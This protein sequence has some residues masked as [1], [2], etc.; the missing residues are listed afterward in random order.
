MPSDVWET[1]T[2]KLYFSP[3]VRYLIGVLPFCLRNPGADVCHTKADRLVTFLFL[4]SGAQLDI[5]LQFSLPTLV[6]D[7][8]KIKILSNF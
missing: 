3:V 5:I 1:E 4:T 7:G 8:Q 2:G 6:T